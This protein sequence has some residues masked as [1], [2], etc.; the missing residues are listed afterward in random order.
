MKSSF[1][2]G[3]CRIFLL[4]WSL[5]ALLL[6]GTLPAWIAITNN[7]AFADT[8]STTIVSEEET[9]TLSGIVWVDFNRNG[10]FEAQ[11]PIAAGQTVFV[12]PDSDSDFAQIL[13]L[14]TNQLGEFSATNLV[15][16]SYRVWTPDQTAESAMRVQVTTDRIGNLIRLPLVGFTLFVPHITR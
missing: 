7:K 6:L 11:E 13:V 10:L 5:T 16:G 8:A 12:T 14:T 2:A 1:L 3:S 15:P 4:R 9:G